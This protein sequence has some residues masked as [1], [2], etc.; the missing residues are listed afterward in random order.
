MINSER[1]VPMTETNLLTEFSVMLSIAGVSYTVVEAT[2]P[3]VFSVTTTGTK[4]ANEPVKT[5]DIT[6]ASATIYFVAAYDYAGFTLNGTAVSTEGD[7]VKPDGSTLY[8]A[9]LASG[10]VT[11][12]KIGA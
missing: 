11:I 12:A 8:T 7:I 3:G 6:A 9:T 4:L 10:T 1:I 5:A 2:E